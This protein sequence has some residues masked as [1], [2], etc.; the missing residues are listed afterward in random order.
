[1]PRTQCQ[2]GRCADPNTI[3]NCEHRGWGAGG[4]TRRPTNRGS[5]GGSFGATQALFETFSRLTKE[6]LSITSRAINNDGYHRTLSL[7][8]YCSLSLSLSLPL[9]LCLSLTSSISL[10]LDP[11][12]YLPSYPSISQSIHPSIHPSSIHP[13]I[14]PSVRPSIHPYI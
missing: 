1:M 7:S 13:F 11:S 8:L 12:E 10:S 5:A 2:H 4:A 9:S 6:P 3:K 14:H